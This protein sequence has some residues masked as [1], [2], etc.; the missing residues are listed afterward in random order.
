LLLLLLRVAVIAAFVIAIAR[1]SVPAADYSLSF[2]ET[3]TL[4]GVI[5]AAVAVYYGMSFRW[6]SKELAAHELKL[7]QSQLRSRSIGAAVLLV[8][9][10]VV[11]PY[12]RRIAAEL[13]SPTPAGDVTLPVAAVFLFDTSLS[14]EYQQ[15]GQTRLDVAREVALAHLSDLPGGSRVAVADVGSDH[16]MLF[17]STLAGAKLQMESREPRPLRLPLNDR[18]RAA[19]KLH[20]DD[21]RRTLSEQEAIPEDRRRDRYLRRVYVLTDLAKSAWRIGGTSRL[22]ADLERLASINLFVID[23]GQTDP[24]NMAIVD[25]GPLRPRVA[26][27]GEVY[28]RATVT[29]V[30]GDGEQ[31]NIELLLDDG[32]GRAIKVDQQPV[33]PVDGTPHIVEFKPQVITS[34]PI[35]HGEVRLVSSDPAPFDDV[36]YF[37]VQSRPPIR[38]LTIA[39]RGNHA[40]AWNTALEVQRYKTAVRSP[41]ELAR[42]ELSDYDVICL[43]NVPSLDNQQWYALGQFVEK[44]GGLAVFLGSDAISPA[45]YGGDQPQVFLPGAP[46]LHTAPGVRYLRV[47]S[48]QHPMLLALVQDDYLSLLETVDVER[49]WQVVPA[50]GAATLIEYNDDDQTAALLERVYGRGRVMM[51]TTAVDIKGIH[52]QEWNML[53]NPSGPVFTFLA[54]ADEM[55]RHLARDSGVRLTYSAG[56]LPVLRLNEHPAERAFLL[57]QP[58]FRQTRLTLAAG[59]SLL[60]V[61]DVGDLGQYNLKP[62]DGSATVVSGFS[63]NPPSGES[64]FTRVSAEELAQIFGAGRYQVARSIDE[65]QEEINIADLGRELFPLILAAAVLIFLAEHFLANWFYDDEPGTAASRV[66]WGTTSS[67][68]ASSSLL[69]SGELMRQ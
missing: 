68:P 9:L 34:T 15:E 32:T 55:V 36:R 26:I 38:V 10:T 64:D 4:L 20:E 48:P 37:T 63:V 40:D 2:S 19:L 33:R 31:Q 54:F 28:I 41:D 43:I 51:L 59:E 6:R 7:R 11:W 50:E 21:R 61:P 23:V 69:T 25:A 24:P 27:G 56:E 49:F 18:I 5:A 39:P 35:V 8:L 58:E 45:N 30:G 16:P 17:Q 3:L 14:M 42:V 44:G 57:Q 62:A 65:L 66:T 60:S 29:R 46:Q 52:W 53:P 22:A 12:Q 47:T 1:P 13:K 67:Q